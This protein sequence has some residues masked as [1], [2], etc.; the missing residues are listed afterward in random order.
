[1]VSKPNALFCRTQQSLS[2]VL[3]IL[4]AASAQMKAREVG[5]R[6]IVSSIASS[7]RAQRRVVS[8]IPST[9][10][11]TKST[12]SRVSPRAMEAARAQHPSW[13]QHVL[14][15][16]TVP[17]IL[18][19][20]LHVGCTS[21]AIDTGNS[22]SSRSL[23]GNTSA[24]KRPDV[25]VELRNLG[26]EIVLTSRDLTTRIHA[27]ELHTEISFTSQRFTTRARCCISYF[28]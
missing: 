22:S 8:E 16:R 1:M 14:S 19:V 18:R 21:S 15:T 24:F 6:S 2:A 26:C 10:V 27:Q 11:P 20:Y 25:Q 12:K 9:K 4:L 28:L 5:T 13:T 17:V 23:E 3:K 7:A